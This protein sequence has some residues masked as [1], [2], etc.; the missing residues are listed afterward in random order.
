MNEVDKFE[1]IELFIKGELKG[2]ELQQFT[3]QIEQNPELKAEV[4]F[5]SDLIG[6]F[7]ETEVMAFRKKMEEVKKELD[8][9]EASVAKIVPMRRWMA[10]AASFLLLVF[11]GYGVWQM[12]YATPTPDSVYA[13]YFEGSKDLP[14]EALTRTATTDDNMTE[15]T[16][17]WEAVQQSY[18]QE[19]YTQAL[20]NLENFE[21]QF[22]TWSAE[23]A[24]D[25]RFQKALIFLA[26]GQISKA[27]PLLENVRNDRLF[28]EDAHWYLGLAYLKM[29]DKKAAKEIF[30]SVNKNEWSKNRRE[31][32][33][34][35]LEYLGE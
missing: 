29:D 30:L 33:P 22:P 28:K 25:L 23:N 7:A 13:N 4:D 35:L 19:N 5:H 9:S 20:S 6:V 18:Q 32:L 11:V 31:Q 17:A 21:R 1:Q 2:Q 16:K 27:I 26:D 3:Q 8:T 34:S 10:I 15:R 24:I 12:L 14:L